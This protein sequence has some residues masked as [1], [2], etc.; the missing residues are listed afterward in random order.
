MM[1]ALN[2]RSDIGIPGKPAR[3]LLPMTRTS[4]IFS[5]SLGIPEIDVSLNKTIEE[6][7]KISHQR[8]LFIL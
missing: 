2:R 6:A 4:P 8:K 7:E 1:K 3:R 5:S